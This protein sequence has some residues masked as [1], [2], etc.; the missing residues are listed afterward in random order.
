MFGNFI[1]KAEFCSNNAISN[2]QTFLNQEA[3][4]Y[5]KL[6][7]SLNQILRVWSKYRL[8]SHFN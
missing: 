2:Q 4:R 7:G 3:S 6:A 1:L 5:S 8:I